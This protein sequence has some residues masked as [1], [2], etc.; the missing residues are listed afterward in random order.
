MRGIQGLIWEPSILDADLGIKYRGLSIPDCQRLLPSAIPGGEPLPEALLWL[1][2]TGEVPTPLQA[3]S[4]TEELRLRAANVPDHVFT[5]LR[6]LPKHLHPMSQLSIGVTALQSTS[7]FAKAYSSGSVHKTRYWEPVYEDAMNLI[8][9]I[10]VIAAFIYRRVFKDGRMIPAD[11]TLDYAANF[12]HM[13]GLD[14]P[15]FHELMR[16]YLT[17]HADHEGGNVSAH[18]THLVGTALSDPYLAYAAGL[19]GLAGP[20]HGLANQEVLNWLH[21][22]REELGEAPTKDQL[23]GFV[24]KTL[25]AGKVVPGF[26]HA[27][28]RVTD[29][30]YISQR[31]FAQKHLPDDPMFH[32]VSDLFDVVPDAM[33]IDADST[34]NATA[35]CPP[36]PA[37]P[38]ADDLSS[39]Q[40]ATAREQREAQKAD[41]AAGKECPE[42]EISNRS[43]EEDPVVSLTRRGEEGTQRLVEAAEGVLSTLNLV[44]CNGAFWEASSE[45]AG[46]GSASSEQ[47]LHQQEQQQRRTSGL[48][49]DA[50]AAA[51]EMAHLRYKNISS[52]LRSLL[53]R[54]Q[55][56][57]EKG[58][59]NAGRPGIDS[60]GTPGAETQRV[61]VGLH[62]E[63]AAPDSATAPEE[64]PE[65]A[66]E[67]SAAASGAAESR[68][69]EEL[70]AR[71]ATL[72]KQ[73][74]RCNM[75]LR[76]A[77]EALKGIPD[78]AR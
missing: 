9:G 77:M 70:T 64:A 20:L 22:V 72:R 52:E 34:R 18:T 63:S 61:G 33:D 17:I 46:A 43:S 2:I 42:R 60:E 31:E 15:G 57:M 38:N 21:E 45:T 29:P 54:L 44:M 59:K 49:P 51:I 5:V 62:P 4:I 40:T 41:D 36:D 71:A 19:N 76:A 67:P 28:L 50:A 65:A 78:N 8:A 11:P 6:S 47:Q 26:G 13:L 30:R 35:T 73:I 39:P 53:L 56:E 10:P 68:S 23:E 24:W 58:T 69:V 3:A 48:P 7:E 12:A 14:D 16:L 75:R 74:R 32:L 66:P 37:A 1:L 27:V 25:K 55:E